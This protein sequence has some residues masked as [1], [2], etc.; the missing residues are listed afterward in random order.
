MSKNKYKYNPETLRYEKVRRTTKDRFLRVSLFAAPSVAFA[1]IIA[2]IALNTITSPG[3]RQKSRENQFLKERNS[4]MTKRLK[5]MEAVLDDI[6]KRDD[7]IY[8]VIFEAD[9]YSTNARIMGTG[10][11]DKYGSL[12][13]YL[14]SEILINTAEQA[15]RVEKKMYAQ[16]KSFDEVIKLAKNKT[17]LIASIP[18][19]MPI[20]GKDLK[21]VASGYGYRIHP[22]YKVRK[23]HQGMDFTAATGTE[24]HATGDGVVIEVKTTHSGYGKRI[25]IDHGFGYM[26]RYAHMSKFTVKK[27]QKVK[28]GDLIGY[29]GDT[30]TSTGPHLHYEVVKSGKRVNPA[31]F[32]HNDLSPEEYETMLEISSKSNQAFD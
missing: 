8:R 13:G 16:S 25:V 28:R 20:A 3:E 27:G 10:G 30:G 7:N 2:F 19:I 9:P 18:A 4:L 32:Y 6:Q 29:V 26:S 1:A 23:L 24:I 22:I 12:D 21:K 15:D 31:P 11:S 5:E 17:K 14:S